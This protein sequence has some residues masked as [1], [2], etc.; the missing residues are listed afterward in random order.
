MTNPI[1][2]ITDIIERFRV[3]P[4]MCRAEPVLVEPAQP[5]LSPYR[6]P[7]PEPVSRPRVITRVGAWA[8]SSLLTK[9]EATVK[10]AA[11]IGIDEIHFMVADH[12][13]CRAPMVFL[14]RP[15]KGRRAA[16]ISRVR[17]IARVCAEHEVALSLTTWAMP[18]PRY[19]EGLGLYFAAVAREIRDIAPMTEIILDAE[20]PWTRALGANASAWKASAKQLRAVLGP[21]RNNG[22]RIGLT[23]IG[24]AR[25]SALD[26]LA[27]FCDVAV[28]QVYPTT[29]NTL[30]PRTSPKKF[31]ALWTKKFERKEMAIALPA[32]RQGPGM[33]SAA[34]AG[35]REVA[36]DPNSAAMSRVIY[37]SLA[38]VLGSSTKRRFVAG[39]KGG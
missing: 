9:T 35:A 39:I 3:G 23:G 21:L 17:D 22:V 33:M 12:S 34:L 7:A 2:F 1:H 20:E 25:E 30:D 10:A 14:D 4:D 37:W 15:A 6:T 38:H 18:H 36:A 32:Y 8:G 24:Y 29:R 28:P 13:A 31:A 27:E 16:S 11:A 19:I 26:P 5:S